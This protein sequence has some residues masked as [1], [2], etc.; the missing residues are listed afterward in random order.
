MKNEF[1]I[2]PDIRLIC[3]DM[4]THFKLMVDSN[5]LKR[6]RFNDLRH[7]CVSLLVAS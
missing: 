3:D 1:R 2:F 7:S 4:P 5:G 6:L